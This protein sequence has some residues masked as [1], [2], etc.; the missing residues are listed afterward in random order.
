MNAIL[1]YFPLENPVV[2]I[3]AILF[4]IL[5][6]PMLVSRLRIPS[7][8]GL[9]IAGMLLSPNG[10]GIIATTDEIEL[11]GAIGLLYIMFTAGLDLD[12][13]T[14]KTQRVTSVAYGC[15]LFALP[16]GFAFVISH[17][18]LGN[19]IFGALLISLIFS[20]NTL[21]SYPITKRLN[22]SG[23]RAVI[24]A[25]G[26]AVIAD[27]ANLIALAFFK[28]IATQGFDLAN[29]SFIAGKL[30]A[31]VLL[32]V[33][34]FPLLTRLYFRKV[35]SDSER[36]FVF[37]FALLFLSALL[38][39]IFG[40]EPIIGA[41]LAGIT[42]NRFIPASSLLMNKIEFVGNSIFIP[43]FLVYVGFLIDFQSLFSGGGTW[44]YALLFVGISFISKY[45]AAYI[46][47][48]VFHFPAEMRNLIY[49]LN[50]SHAGATIAISLVVYNLGFFAKS[51][52]NA[53]I[54][55]ILFS[56]ILS[57]FVTEF[58][59]RRLA[60]SVS[61]DLPLTPPKYRKILVPFSNPETADLLLNLAV[62][63]T[64]NKSQPICPLSVVSD[65][66][67]STEQ[68]LRNYY[69]LQQ[70]KRNYES[71]DYKVQF[72]TRVENSIVEGISRA[73]KELLINCVV[74]GWSFRANLIGSITNSTLEHLLGQTNAAIFVSRLSGN[75]SLSNTI[76]VFVPANAEFEYGC[77]G[78]ISS[79]VSMC[80]HFSSNLEFVGYEATLNQIAGYLKRI[81]STV[82][83]TYSYITSYEG[84][85]LT[86][87]ETSPLDTVVVIGA[88]AKSVSFNSGYVTSF[89][90]GVRRFSGNVI[91]V[92]P[93]ENSILSTGCESIT[94]DVLSGSFIEDNLSLLARAKSFLHNQAHR[95]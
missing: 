44:N 43:F 57:S 3:G 67:T 5:I 2:I 49:G 19:S 76:R 80:N 62:S 84:L 31:Y 69:R 78:W 7:I 42:L 82:P 24:I 61:R 68:I 38:S 46:A 72:E 50:V 77:S 25:V 1:K 55:L 30:I 37:I 45:L 60:I 28:D 8:V 15:L 71:L 66:Q 35:D 91:L 65:E 54:I 63:I 59:G 81:G 86:I 94:K 21:V 85:Y 51:E 95:K 47:G 93:E 33:L 41:F 90:R 26:A 6:V 52:L 48:R 64:D 83:V 14:F 17:I 92:F 4:V 36:Q 22:I 74:I 11:F 53:I 10:L 9:I 29:F 70:A 18:F 34:G 39:D 79:I 89:Y 73:I 13:N 75:L 88:R 23:H 12:I 58:F 40:L 32:I 27:T 20:T 87:S 16:L 56:C